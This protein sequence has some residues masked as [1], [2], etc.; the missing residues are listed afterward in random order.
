MTV[1]LARRHRHSLSPSHVANLHPSLLSLGSVVVVVHLGHV[2][3]SKG[4]FAGHHICQVWCI[5]MLLTL[6]D[7]VNFF[8]SSA[9]GL[10][11]SEDLEL[12]K[13]QARLTMMKKMITSHL[14][15]SVTMRPTYEAL[16]KYI[17]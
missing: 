9:L 3:H 2:A 12:A 13:P 16:I 10:D 14:H 17:L 11:P 4:H 5:G 8:Q 6:K 15:V 1:Y 7:F